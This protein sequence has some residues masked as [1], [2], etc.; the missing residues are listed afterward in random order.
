MSS[1]APGPTPLF[2]DTGAFYAWYDD[3]DEQHDRAV[4][5]FHGIQTADLPYRP[6]YTSRYVLAELT[7]L[8]LYRKGHAPA[9]SA[10][11]RIRTSS[12]FTVLSVSPEQFATACDEFAR[13]D[14]QQISLV[15]HISAVLAQEHDIEHV[16]AFDSDFAT[17]GFTRVPGETN[18]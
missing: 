14:D 3:D 6:L 4:A 11:E 7:R 10:L 13:Y 8:I 12:V 1:R 17:L 5:V 9:R 2:I 15:D 18:P 16:F